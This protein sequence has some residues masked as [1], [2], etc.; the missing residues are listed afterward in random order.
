M[1]KYGK[2]VLDDLIVLLPCGEL[3]YSSFWRRLTDRRSEHHEDFGYMVSE[4]RV[5]SHEAGYLHTNHF[6]LIQMA[7]EVPGWKRAVFLEHDHEF[8]GGFL[9]KHATYQHPIVGGL[10]VLRDVNEPL[11][12][13]YRWDA[14]REAVEF[15]TAPELKQMLEHQGLYPSD[16]VPLGCTSISREM[17]ERWPKDKPYFSSYINARGTTISLDVWFCRLAQDELGVTPMVDT[18]LWVKHYLKVPFDASLFP[19]WWNRVGAKRAIA[20]VKED[21]RSAVLVKN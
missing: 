12:V 7:L 21:E 10:Y 1:S 6:A 11:P 15:H 19:V 8:P 16:V 2:G 3:G 4:G 20:A 18:S 14:K 9:R 13:I 5:I 17:L